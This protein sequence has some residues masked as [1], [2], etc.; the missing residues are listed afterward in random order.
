MYFNAEL[1]LD[2]HLLVCTSFIANFV[3][4]VAICIQLVSCPA[5][6]LL[7]KLPMAEALSSLRSP[8]DSASN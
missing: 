8:I 3:V 5:T 4:M 7:L 2:F 6:H 1:V